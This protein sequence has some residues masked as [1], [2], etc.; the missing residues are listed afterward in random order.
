MPCPMLWFAEGLVDDAKLPAHPAERLQREVKVFAGVGSGGHDA[1][2]GGA[3][4][5]R[6]EGDGCSEDALH[7][8]AARELL[9]HWGL[10]QNDGR[11]GRLALARI[12]A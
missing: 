7:K 11:D 2:A 1:D 12:E 8:E 6:R 3:A 4:R 10:A 9:R 5:H